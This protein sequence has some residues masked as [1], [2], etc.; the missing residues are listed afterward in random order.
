MLML[1]GIEVAFLGGD[2]RQLEVISKMAEMDA[3]V[4]LFGFDNW[5]NRFSGVKKGEW[6]VDAVDVLKQIDAL[7]LP[8]AGADDD[9]KVESIFS[10][11]ELHLEDRHV[12][13]L[14]KSAKIY[15][16]FAKPYL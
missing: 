15:T 13:S 4:T 11:E 3:S 7:V 9:G 10:A 1:T 5:Q 12:A 6:N 14:P 2:A 16:G 8:A